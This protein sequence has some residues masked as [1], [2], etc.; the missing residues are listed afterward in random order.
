VKA[1]RNWVLADNLFTKLFYVYSPVNRLFRPNR[2][3]G[4]GWDRLGRPRF[5]AGAAIAIFII[6]SD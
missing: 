1:G 6:N 2:G 3:G 4:G 5:R